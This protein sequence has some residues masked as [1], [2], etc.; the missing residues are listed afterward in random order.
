MACRVLWWRTS[1]VVRSVAAKTKTPME[2]EAYIQATNLP[3]VNGYG[4]NIDVL[5]VQAF[6]TKIVVGRD[7]KVAWHSFLGGG[8]NLEQAI[9]NAL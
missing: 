5:N 6:P 9:Q 7:G 2:T 1:A 3:F 8:V 4:A